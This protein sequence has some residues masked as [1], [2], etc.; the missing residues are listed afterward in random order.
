MTRREIRE[1]LDDGCAATLEHADVH[2]QSAIKASRG[3]DHGQVIH[4][5]SVCSLILRHIVLERGARTVGPTTGADM[6]C[7]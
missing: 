4:D 1:L 6:T 2:L 5:A 3:G 7:P